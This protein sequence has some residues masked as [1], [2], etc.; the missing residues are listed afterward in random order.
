MKYAKSVKKII[1]SNSKEILA[2]HI[3]FNIHNLFSEYNKNQ[4]DSFFK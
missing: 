3:S 1:I 4:M 2:T